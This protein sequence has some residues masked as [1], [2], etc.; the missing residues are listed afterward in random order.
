M[1]SREIL[2]SEAILEIIVPNGILECTEE[3]VLSI[4]SAKTRS[5]AFYDELLHFY[6]VIGLPSDS[7]I[8]D[9]ATVT[10][11]FHQLDI[12]VE[13]S[14]NDSYNVSVPSLS[15]IP[16]SFHH[17]IN[18]IRSRSSSTTTPPSIPGSPSSYHHSDKINKMSEGS[19]IYSCPYDPNN[20]DEKMVIVKFKNHWTCVVPL[21]MSV[22][23]MKTRSANPTLSL[24]VSVSLKSSS[25]IV[26]EQDTSN[27]YSHQLFGQM[28]LLAGLADDP[29]FEDSSTPLQI[30]PPRFQ[31]LD[32][33]HKRSLYGP[34]KPIKR[35]CFK[36]L[37]LK[38]ALTV[39]MRTISVSPL[40][41]ALMISV[42]IENNSAEI[43]ASFAM[44]SIKID[45]PYSF[46][47]RY[48]CTQDKTTN[49]F[50]LVL[51]PF[52]QVSF[53]YN[54]VILEKPSLPTPPTQQYYLPSSS[55]SSRG[56]SR[57]SSVSSI[58]SN[59]IP[60]SS[61]A[62]DRQ[63]SL[64]IRIRGSPILKNEKIHS[65]ES[66]W[67]CML[68]LSSLLKRDNSIPINK[69]IQQSQQNSRFTVSQTSVSSRN[70]TFLSTDVSTPTSTK[71]FNSDLNIKKHW[72]VPSAL[73]SINGTLIGGR[74]PKQKIVVDSGDCVAVS[75]SVNSEVVV[76]Q[77]FNV[78]ITIFNKSSEIKKFTIKV[79]NKSQLQNNTSPLSIVTK[80]P[81]DSYEDISMLS[82]RG[83]LSNKIEPFIDESDFLKKHL[84]F[85]TFDADLVCLENNVCTR[86]IRPL[87]C[88]TVSIRFIA[89]KESL[90]V[91]DL[92]QLVNIDT[93]F[94]TNLRN[95][96]E[97]LIRSRTDVTMLNPEIENNSIFNDVIPIRKQLIVS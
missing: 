33:V 30:S 19:V 77:I 80:L 72:S 15:P 40:D 48:D 82:I 84:E 70:S 86:P 31:M 44:D 35:N 58:F 10:A 5:Q 64:S 41:N 12:N 71:T 43:A 8:Y 28:N 87:T 20:V 38:N 73:E 74:V 62:E 42:E 90:H 36:S 25:S 6:L 91:I 68:D 88:E 9:L 46:V 34:I 93:G 54:I 13:A 61:P 49:D 94:V 75:F 83:N 37:S 52:D 69:I 97:I 18:S 57:R 95:V 27:L 53:L 26:N 65:I 21:K 24:N 89:M 60:T 4:L 23:F 16:R 78:Q 92:V 67:N 1:I 11:F 59:R 39:R 14:L 76:G 32:S 55:M 63:R 2:L 47:T 51:N 56:S 45:V 85:E 96:L 7:T 22:N 81:S 66:K 50:P 79:P 3:R 17:S 29:A